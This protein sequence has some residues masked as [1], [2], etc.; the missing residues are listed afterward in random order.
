MKKNCGEGKSIF[1]TEEIISSKFSIFILEKKKYL[2]W[3]IAKKQI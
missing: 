3:R 1:I 2:S